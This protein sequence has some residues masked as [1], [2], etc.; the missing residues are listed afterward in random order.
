LRKPETQKMSMETDA[1]G[2]GFKPGERAFLR[3]TMKITTQMGPKSPK[4][5]RA[6]ER[7]IGEGAPDETSM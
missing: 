6:W 1:S 4:G 5:S 3:A 2:V 7:E